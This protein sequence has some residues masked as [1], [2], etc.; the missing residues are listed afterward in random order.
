MISKIEKKIDHEMGDFSEI[1]PQLLRQ[2]LFLVF[3]IGAGVSLSALLMDRFVF[4]RYETNNTTLLFLA[5]TISFLL[6]ILMIKIRRVSARGLQV[7][8]YFVVAVN[9]LLLTG[10]AAVYSPRI[11]RIYG[12]SLLLYSHAAFVPARVLVQLLIGLTTVLVYPLGQFLAY[13]FLPEVHEIWM[14]EGGFS[15]FMAAT[16]SHSVDILILSVISVLV[17][18]TLYHFRF[19][20]ERAERLGN[21]ILKKEIGHGGMGTIYEASHAFLARPTAI[22]VLT[23]KKEDPQMARVRFDREV[24][25]VSSLTHPNTITIFDYGHASD[26]TFYYAMELLEGMDLEEMVKQFGPLPAD[27]AIHLLTQ[28]CGSLSEAHEKGFVHRDIKPSNIFITHRGGIYDFVKVL[29]FGLAKEF[30]ESLDPTLTESGYYLGTPRYT[31][32]ECV[33]N[34]THIDRRTDLYMLGCVAYWILTGHSPFEKDSGMEMMIDHVKT[35]PP[36]PSAMGKE[37]IPEELDRI[38]MKCLEKDPEFRFQTAPELE[39]A[40]DQVPLSKPWTQAEARGW[41][42][43]NFSDHLL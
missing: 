11:P 3:V 8:D 28:V 19:H 4:R 42:M 18:K 9:I 36:K 25:L 1:D 41:W 31:A 23:P 30:R 22:K 7:I 38:V 5:H 29:D 16:A 21:Y 37:P 6:G 12:Y 2:R 15:S 39:N 10:G 24:K 43:K 13:Y 20:L 35:L 27:R 40:L 17:T 34:P 33:I 32:P 26:Q 14:R